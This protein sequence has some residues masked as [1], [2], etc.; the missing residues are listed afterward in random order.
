MAKD[1][2]PETEKAPLPPW[3]D[4]LKKLM[5]AN[6]P[7]FYRGNAILAESD[8][9]RRDARRYDFFIFNP[10]TD[11]PIAAFRVR[12]VLADDPKDSNKTWH[13][14]EAGIIPRLKKQQNT[15]ITREAELAQL[16]KDLGF[17]ARPFEAFSRNIELY[18][19]WLRTENKGMLQDENISTYARIATLKIAKPQQ[20]DGPFM[21]SVRQSNLVSKDPEIRA[22]LAQALSEVMKTDREAFADRVLNKPWTLVPLDEKLYAKAPAA[23]HASKQD[24][25]P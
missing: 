23:F 18:C 7:L 5:A 24:K 1:P 10:D 8:Y 6:S 17:A 12:H 2:T 14:V 21:Q 13:T 9:S 20:E 11:S 22:L 4:E 16:V 19:Y 25:T 3:V 15:G